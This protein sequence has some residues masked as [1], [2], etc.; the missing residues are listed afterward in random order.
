[1]PVP[2]KLINVNLFAVT[3]PSVKEL[4]FII[5]NTNEQLDSLRLELQHALHKNVTS[6]S[7]RGGAVACIAIPTIFGVVCGATV[8]AAS[9]AFGMGISGAAIACTVALV[10]A[11]LRKL[12]DDIEEDRRTTRRTLRA[13]KEKSALKDYQ[14]ASERN[15]QIVKRTLR[16]KKKSRLKDV[17]AVID[18]NR[19]AGKQTSAV[20]QTLEV[21]YTTIP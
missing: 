4:E 5:T 19:Q 13:G 18:K 14:D 15:R 7:S 9:I 11:S 20:T 16:G 3:D 17:Q 2:V 1:M 10:S 12:G 21:Y 6:A 8:G